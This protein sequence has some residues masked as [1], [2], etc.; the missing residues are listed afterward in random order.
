MLLLVSQ[1]Q[2]TN[3]NSKQ[4]LNATIISFI[5]NFMSSVLFFI[6]IVLLTWESGCYSWNF[7]NTFDVTSIS[8]VILTSAILIKL[9]VGPWLSGNYHSY[10]GYSLLYLV[11]YT[12]N[13]VIILTP[14]LI[15]LYLNLGNTLIAA[16]SLLS[17]IIYISGTLHTVRSVKSLFAYSTVIIY[18][19]LFLICLV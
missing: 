1:K 9:G 4:H 13:F 7:L 11:I 17:I 18:F 16:I 19:Y 6:Y 8:S 15:W 10:A 12:I 3:F 5:L 2:T 14:V